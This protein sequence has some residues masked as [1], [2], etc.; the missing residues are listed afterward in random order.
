MLKA[1]RRNRTEGWMAESVVVETPPQ[2]KGEGGSPRSSG[3]LRKA[4]KG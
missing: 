2:L 4:E 1:R 3:E